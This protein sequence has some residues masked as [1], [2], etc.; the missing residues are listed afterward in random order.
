MLKSSNPSALGKRIFLREV[1]GENSF[2]MSRRPPLILPFMC[3]ERTDAFF[4]RAMA[5]AGVRLGSCDIRVPATPATIAVEKLVTGPL[6]RSYPSND[7]HTMSTHGAAISTC[8]P[9]F[10]YGGVAYSAGRE[11]YGWPAPDSHQLA[12]G[13]LTTSSCRTVGSEAPIGEHRFGPH[14]WCVD[15]ATGKR[16]RQRL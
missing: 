15:S 5:C 11:R 14:G 2:A 6:I 4:N 3:G 8:L 9:K 12:V 16:P 10:I 13:P 7:S 1:Y